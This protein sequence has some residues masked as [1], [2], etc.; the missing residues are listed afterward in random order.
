MTTETNIRVVFEAFDA[1]KALA[2]HPI[3]NSFGEPMAVRRLFAWRLRR[4]LG[5]SYI[6]SVNQDGTDGCYYNIDGTTY[7]CKI[8]GLRLFLVKPAEANRE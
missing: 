3:V 2:G 6:M 5:M 7:P 8:N 1:A 4:L